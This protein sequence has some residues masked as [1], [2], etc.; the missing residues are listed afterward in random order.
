MK[1]NLDPKFVGMAALKE[2]QAETLDLFRRCAAEGNWLGIHRS[3]FD[4]W[5]FPIDEPSSYAFMYTV[6]E[7]DIAELKE[8]AAYV[9]RYLE[10]ASI[11][12]RSWGWDLENVRPVTK[13]GKGQTW[14]EWPIR[15]YKATK[16]LHLFGC[17]P[18]FQSLRAYGRGLLAM[19][20]S[21]DYSRD[22]TYLFR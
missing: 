7:G 21:F 12:A 9:E 6:Y 14:Q 19:G 18:Q 16:S 22:I 20:H 11:L 13:P 8:D 3:H 4:W 15:L 1:R 5:M 2:K 10:G 17:E